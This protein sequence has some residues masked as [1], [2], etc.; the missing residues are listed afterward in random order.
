MNN[1]AYVFEVNAFGVQRDGLVTEGQ[2]TDYSYNSTWQSEGRLTKDGFVVLIAIPFK[3]LRFSNDDVQSWGIALGRYIPR[4]SESSYWPVITPRIAGFVSQMGVAEGLRNVGAGY[5]ARIVPYWAFTQARYLDENVPASVLRVDRRGGVDASVVTKDGVTIDVTV[6]PDFAQVAP[7]SP[8]VTINR[9]FEVFFPERRPFFI[10]N[11]GYF[12][13]PESFVFS[14]RIAD[15][16]FGTRV[17]GKVGGWVIGALVADDRTEGPRVPADNR[18]SGNRTGNAIVRI[19][20]D[21]GAESLVGVLATARVFGSRSSRLV[22]ADTRLK[23]SPTWIF[24]GQA[25]RSD[26]RTLDGD[27]QQGSAVHAT[28]AR[29]GRNL[30]Y[31][32]IYRE[33]SR[34]FEAALGFIN[35]VDLRE[36]RHYMGYLHHL[37]GGPVT[38]FGPSVSTAMDWNFTGVRQDWSVDPGVHIYFRR[39]AAISLY[40]QESWERFG[41]IGFRKHSTIVSG[42]SS[43]SKVVSVNGSLTWG[44][45][46][47]YSPANGLDPSLG[48]SDTVS[49]GLT[50]R[51]GD[52][53][54]IDESYYFS[55][56]RTR[57]GPLGGAPVTD[58]FTNHLSRTTAS[59]QMT[60]ALSLRAIADYRTLVPDAGLI[61]QTL[62]KRLTWDLLATYLVNPFTAVYVGYTEGRSNLE[63]DPADRQKL[64]V[65]TSPSAPAF[66]QLFLKL[67]YRLG[68]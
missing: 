50:I 37:D 55:R 12:S 14:R 31:F 45:G 63:I 10:E 23:L 4:N 43:Q 60:K 56:L 33:L 24:T 52:R 22:A 44:V 46:P 51:P 62:N 47:N 28:L 5:S 57:A 16:Q 39:Q 34:D 40:R 1:A 3:S 6:N 17:T 29:N 30:S 61:A 66:R 65:L 18:L 53:V 54:K 58:I 11:A 64:R 19:Q 42:Y 9:R 49:L 68:L 13:T 2:G 7:D 59:L 41:G 26:S 48:S 32:S 25:A 21:V 67:S 35:R 38:S 8:Q 27:R 15:P 20:R 36:T